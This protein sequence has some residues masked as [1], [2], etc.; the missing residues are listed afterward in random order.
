MEAFFTNRTNNQLRSRFTSIRGKENRKTKSAPQ[1][2]SESTV[3]ETDVESLDE[4]NPI[5]IL[6]L[7]EPIVN[8]IKIV[9]PEEI[10]SLQ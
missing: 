1:V 6:N 5:D 10:E 2:T 4:R 7:N 3:S 8:E 9:G